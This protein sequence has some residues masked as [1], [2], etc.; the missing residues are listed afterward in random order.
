M[1]RVL[2]GPWWCPQK[3]IFKGVNTVLS[4]TVQKKLNPIKINFISLFALF[5]VQKSYMFAIIK[6]SYV[7]VFLA[8]SGSSVSPEGFKFWTNWVCLLL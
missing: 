6:K 4:R 2:L 7:Y 8:S 1:W 5:N 3:K